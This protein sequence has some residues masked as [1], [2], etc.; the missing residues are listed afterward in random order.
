MYKLALQ[1]APWDA[2]AYVN[3]AVILERLNRK[4]AALTYW[5][6]YQR[7]FPASRRAKE[8]AKRIELLQKM[9]KTESKGR[10]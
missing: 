4:Q 1:I 9:V 7:L 8:I 6:K 2:A 10:R 3:A 5:L